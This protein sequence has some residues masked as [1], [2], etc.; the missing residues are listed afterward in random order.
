MS[1]IQ[2]E[3]IGP[4]AASP[5]VKWTNM[6]TSDT[7][8]PLVNWNQYPDKTVQVTGGSADIE[9]SN[10]GVN[11]VTLTDVRGTSLAGIEPTELYVIFENPLYI[12][13]VAKA[14]A[15]SVVITG[16]R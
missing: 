14:G 13:P 5:V 12:R 1:V 15:T 7:G 9:G 11:W 6:A 10:D 16:A 8:A 3:V 4:Q 2:G